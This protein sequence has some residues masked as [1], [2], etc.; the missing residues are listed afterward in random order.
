MVEQF[1]MATDKQVR[2][3]VQV[4]Q[5][6]DEQGMMRLCTLDDLDSDEYYDPLEAGAHPILRIDEIPDLK[7]TNT[8]RKVYLG[9][10][11]TGKT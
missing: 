11:W 4:A 8:Y 6:V 2:S 9:R 3:E 10:L 7:G 5:D 1:E